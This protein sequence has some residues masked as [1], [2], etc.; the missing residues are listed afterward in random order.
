[1][2][3][4]RSGLWRCRQNVL[5]G[6]AA[7]DLGSAGAETG[8]A[9]G[10][11][12]VWGDGD[13]G[14]AVANS[15]VDATSGVFDRG[16]EQRR[17]GN[18]VEPAA[19]R[20]DVADV[21]G[22]VL[23]AGAHEAGADSGDVDVVPA[24]LGVQAFGE[25]DEGELG[26]GVGQHVRHGDLAADGGDVDD[27]G[28][29][30][31]AGH[32]LLLAQARESGPDEMQRAV[33]V[34]VHSAVEGIERLRFGGADLDDAGVVDEDVDATEVSE[35]FGDDAAAFGRIGEVGVNE[36]EVLRVKVWVLGEKHLLRGGELEAVAG[37][38]D[39]A[40]RAAR[41]ARRDGVAKTAGAS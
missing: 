41:E 34:D 3:A 19:L 36:V 16:G 27:G 1:M 6:E 28:A 37:G 12:R 4:L 35:D 8:D 25:A 14:T 22:V 31:P 26:G 15:R 20:V 24:K 38:E 30:G 33:E 17:A 29:A 11:P 18:E 9:G 23:A 21:V 13:L 10:E 39:K 40:Y 5:V 7:K 2:D 32:G